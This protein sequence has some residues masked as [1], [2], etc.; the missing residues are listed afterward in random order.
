MNK[1][2]R[3]SQEERVL[4]H[5]MKNGNITSMDAF[6]LYHITRLSAIIFTLRDKGYDIDTQMIHKNGHHFAKYVM[7][8]EL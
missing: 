8:R 3:V 4:N 6:Y 1:N 7:E 5:L 2:K